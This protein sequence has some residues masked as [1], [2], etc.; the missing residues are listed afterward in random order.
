V[1]RLFEGDHAYIVQDSG[2][3]IIFMIPYERDFTLI[4]TT[5]LAI[6]DIAEGR[7]I[8]PAEVDY[9]CAEVSRYARR[10]VTPGQVAWSYSGVRPLY[11][12]GSDDPSAITRDYTLVLD[13]GDDGDDGNGGAQAPQLSVY[14]GKITTY[15]KLAEA[16]L[17]KLA[18]WLGHARG[19]RRAGWT[20]GEAL[21]GGTLGPGGQAA[22]LHALC[23]RYP[24][25][26]AD[27]LQG[28]VRRHGTLA[29]DILGDAARLS[30]LGEAF[31]GQLYE[32]EVEYL[33]AHEWA[34]E[35]ADILWRRTKAGLHMTPGQRDYFAEFMTLGRL[36]RQLP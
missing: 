32:R 25:L 16:A 35:A 28:L 24:G 23:L 34:E 9:L 20:A 17:D 36:A 6:D 1:P 18:P 11:D 5:D 27:Y 2:K 7:A 21:P 26:P 15:R 3:R 31:G 33:V 12:D 13:D 22:F 30:D 8:S 29:V 4:G 19:N 14:G 10:P